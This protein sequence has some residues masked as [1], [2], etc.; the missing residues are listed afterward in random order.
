M[1]DQCRLKRR[2]VQQWRRARSRTI[3]PVALELPIC[4]PKQDLKP[5]SDDIC[6][7][8]A[9]WIDRIDGSLGNAPQLA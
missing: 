1:R 7:A 4:N 5:Q 8:M 2:P 6:G 3:D 9:R